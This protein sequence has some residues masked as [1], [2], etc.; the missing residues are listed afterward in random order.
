VDDV[1]DLDDVE[2]EIGNRLMNNTLGIEVVPIVAERWMD[3]W[4]GRL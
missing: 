1:R 3:G 2:M 4:M